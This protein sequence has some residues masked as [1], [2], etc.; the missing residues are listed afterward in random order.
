MPQECSSILYYIPDKWTGK[1]LMLWVVKMSNYPGL[2]HSTTKCNWTKTTVKPLNSFI[3]CSTLQICRSY[4]H[5]IQLQ[6][7]KLYAHQYMIPMEINMKNSTHNIYVNPSLQGQTACSSPFKRAQLHK[8][9]KLLELL[10]RHGRKFIPLLSH[11]S[12][13]IRCA[14]L[15]IYNKCISS[16]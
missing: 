3:T 12:K 1:G 8:N 4:L 10:S 6:Q 15:L 7:Y 14:F 9:G 16:I 2:V 13:N 11:Y 5:L